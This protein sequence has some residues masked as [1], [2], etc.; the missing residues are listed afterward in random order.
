MRMGNQNALVRLRSMLGSQAKVARALGMTDEQV[1]R[2]SRGKYPV[3]EY[4]AAVAELLEAL[5]IKDW[6]ERWKR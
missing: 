2:I 1:S 3:P 4:M 6:P 5:P